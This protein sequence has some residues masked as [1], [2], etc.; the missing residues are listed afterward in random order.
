LLRRLVRPRRHLNRRLFLAV[1]A[2]AVALAMATG[3]AF[4]AGLLTTRPISEVPAAIFQQHFQQQ[5]HGTTGKGSAGPGET[6]TLAGAQQRAGFQ[7]RTL[8]GIPGVKLNRVTS[9]TITFRDGS[10]EPMIELDYELGDVRVIA[11]EIKD[12]H[13]DAP[14]EVPILS[15]NM[16]IERID[17][18]QYLVIADETGKVRDI[19]FKTS[20]GI[21]FSVN[22][23]GPPYPNTVGPGGVD[24]EFARNVI[25]HLS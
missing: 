20:E 23:F 19:Q 16:R 21:V 12:P 3:A 11:T 22:F 15:P 25:R 7:A 2:A 13:P 8:K 6:G 17:D 9:N 5:H 10:R 18:S 1:L 14:F 4:A 24:V